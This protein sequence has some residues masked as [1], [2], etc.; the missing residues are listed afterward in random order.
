M[1]TLETLAAA[2]AD[3]LEPPRK[4]AA[5]A[6][7]S[8]DANADVDAELARRAAA[9]LMRWI[10]THGLDGSVLLAGWEIG[11]RGQLGSEGLGGLLDRTSAA[12]YAVWDAVASRGATLTPEELAALAARLRVA[13]RMLTRSAAKGFIA[14]RDQSHRRWLRELRHDLRNPIGA[15]KN[16]VA[17]LEE[18]RDDSGTVQR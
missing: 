7:R 14:G 15:I 13:A 5:G 18:T 16:A 2:V 11:M 8:A 17:L 12:E 3:Q 1:Q 6:D 10:A 4:A 9:A